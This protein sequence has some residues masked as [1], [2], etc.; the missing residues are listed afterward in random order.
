MFPQM[1]AL[2]NSPTYRRSLAQRLEQER[3]AANNGTIPGGLAS[4]INAGTAAYLRARDEGDR[5]KAQ[6][7]L[8]GGIT[9]ATDIG[10]M[11]EDQIPAG[12]DGALYRLGQLE[13]NPYAGRL[14]QMLTFEQMQRQQEAE[15]QRQAFQMQLAR[16]QMNNQA[17]IQAAA[18]GRSSVNVN[19]G[20]AP[21]L[22]TIPQGYQ[23]VFD[24]GTQSYNMQPVAGG[25]AARDIAAE[26]E[27]KGLRNEGTA[28]SG[29]IVLEDIGRMRRA[30][31]SQPWYSPVTGLG[32]AV[33]SALPGSGAYNTARI[34]DSIRANIGFDRLNQMRQESP[35]GGALGQ[36]TERELNF[37]QSVLGSLDTAQSED[38]ILYNL[39]RLDGIYRGIVRKAA[40]YPNAAKYGFGQGGDIG[41]GIQSMPQQSQPPSGAMDMRSLSDEQLRR[42]INGQ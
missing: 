2:E 13:D 32:G 3:E 9:E 36:V 29:G 12:P 16:D 25:P 22:G 35:T 39:E 17:R 31:Q 4:M 14:S 28:R 23:V 19:A 6:K 21:R 18:A 15:A 20:G 8:M 10:E 38:Q 37:L 7:A 42:I 40:A 1:M 11:G 41:S 30:I 33:L 5:S 27:A 34:A 26:E 24:P